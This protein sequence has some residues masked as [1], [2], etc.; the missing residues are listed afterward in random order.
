MEWARCRGSGS[1]WYNQ[2]YTWRYRTNWCSSSWRGSL[3]NRSGHSDMTLV[4]HTSFVFASLTKWVWPSFLYHTDIVPLD[5]T[6]CNYWWILACNQGSW[7]RCVFWFHL[8]TRRDWSCGYWHW[9][10]Y[11]L[12]KGCTPYGYCQSSRPFSEGIRGQKSN[13][14]TFLFLGSQFLFR[15]C[16]YHLSFA[17]YVI[18]QVL[19]AIR[20]S[21]YVQLLLEWSWRLLWCIKSKT[22]NTATLYSLSGIYQLP[23]WR[24]FL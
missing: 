22:E 6:V 3:E 24:F 19:T 1:W 14:F 10:S 9:G 13:Q 4:L 16:W 21:E 17:M 18:M 15:W 11:F 8:Q 7:W 23:C 5:F 20:K 2:H 12:W